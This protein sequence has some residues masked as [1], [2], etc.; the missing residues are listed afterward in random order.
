LPVG[1]DNGAHVTEQLDGLENVD[2]ISAKGP[3]DTKRQVTECFDGKLE[4]IRACI[5][6]GQRALDM[7]SSW[8]G[9]CTLTHKTVPEKIAREASQAPKH[10]VKG[11]ARSVAVGMV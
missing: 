8:L 3:V 4:R 10:G 9:W 11:S 2:E 1:D 7:E 6:R 5:G